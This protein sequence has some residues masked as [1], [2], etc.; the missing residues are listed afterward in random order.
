V[1]AVITNPGPNAV[2]DLYCPVCEKNFISGERC[3][4]DNVKL[5]R[6][7]GTDP[8]LGRELDGRYTILEKLGAGGM[9]AVYR[10]NQRSVGREVAVKVVGNLVA[11]PD[12]IKRFLREAKLAG[13]LDHPSAVQVLDFGQTDD[14]LFYLVMELIRGQTLDVMLERDGVLSPERVVRIGVQICDALECAHAL[15]IV[16]RDLKP[17]NIMVLA[18]GR[19][20]IKVLDFGLAKSLSPDQTSTTMTGAGAMLG[21][22]AFMPPELATGQRCDGRADLYSLGCI[23]YLLGTG[24]LPFESDSIHELIAMHGMEPAPIMPGVPVGLARAVDRLLAKDPGDRFQTAAETREAL[25]DCLDPTRATIYDSRTSYPALATTPPIAT[26]MPINV[27]VAA[28]I[29]STVRPASKRPDSVEQ[30]RRRRWLWFVLAGAL[31]GGGA[32]AVFVMTNDKPAVES[33]TTEL[34]PVTEPKPA[35]GS[36]P[37]TESK[38]KTDPKPKAEPES[39][40]ATDPNT[41]K[42]PE[43]PP[44]EAKQAGSAAKPEDRGATRPDKPEVASP[45]VK[46][47]PTRLKPHSVKPGK[48]PVKDSPPTAAPPTPAPPTPAPPTPAPPTNPDEPKLPF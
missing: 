42:R 45:P 23:L 43:T 20:L 3:P 26:P 35:G 5:V 25:E 18:H 29:A 4:T 44:T 31:A 2:G 47:I 34:N 12:A 21:T 40:P 10:A 37:P 17:A 28:A 15:S 22:P 7:S 6:L 38:P 32:A 48:P 13:K 8:F 41:D 27:P 33:K 39:K 14:G 16:H 1:E 30:P 19:D 9:G 24:R 46:P 11:E 36:N